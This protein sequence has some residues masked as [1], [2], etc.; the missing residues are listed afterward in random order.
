MDINISLL[1]DPLHNSRLAKT[2]IHPQCPMFIGVHIFLPQIHQ[3]ILEYGSTPYTCFTYESII[4]CILR[5][6]NAS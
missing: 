4:T 5:A 2:M 1:E 3:E 6:T